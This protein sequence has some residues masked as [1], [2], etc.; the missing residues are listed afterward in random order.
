MVQPC[1]T[2]DTVENSSN[3]KR[4]EEKSL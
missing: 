1:F 2:H 4:R 3:S